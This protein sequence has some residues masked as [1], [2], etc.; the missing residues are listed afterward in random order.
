M[1]YLTQTL[2]ALA[3]AAVLAACGGGDGLAVAGV[4]P[5]PSATDTAAGPVSVEGCVADSHGRAP[6]VAV[7]ALDA[8]GRLLASA[9]ADDGGVFRMHVPAHQRVRFAAATPGVEALDVLTGSRAMTLA[10]CL[11]AA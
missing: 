9:L 6:A 4:L 1:N 11:R 2:A 3:A 10:G 8:D 5:A 7:Y